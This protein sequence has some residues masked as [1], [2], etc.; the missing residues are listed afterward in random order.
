[1]ENSL[2]PSAIA[3]GKPQ[4]TPLR[5]ILSVGWPVMLQTFV[6]VGSSLGQ[7]MLLSVC[8]DELTLA[9][10]SLA[11]V[12]CNLLGYFVTWGFCAGYDTIASQAWGAG[13]RRQIGVVGQR[14]VLMQVVCICAPMSIAW[15]YATYILET[16][17]Q[18]RAV[19]EQA[20]IY[21]RLSLPSL[22]TNTVLCVLSKALLAMGKSTPVSVVSIVRTV[23]LG[24]LLVLLVYYPLSL[25]LTGAALANTISSCAA[26]LMLGTYALCDA[27]CRSCWPGCTG[28]VWRRWCNYLTL[29]LP[30]CLMM[31]CEALSWDI[32]SFLA[33]L[34]HTATGARGYKPQ[35]IIAAQGLLQSI[36]SSTCV[37]PGKDGRR[38]HSHPQP[39]SRAQVR[40]A[41]R[42]GPWHCNP[43]RQRSRRRRCEECRDGCAPR[44]SSGPRKHTADRRSSRAAPRADCALLSATGRCQR[45][46]HANAAVRL[47][48]SRR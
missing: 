21:A 26:P 23:L 5:V 13:E 37:R 11:N 14:V 33:G 1:M 22:F 8:T 12:L 29:G 15:W 30:A 6:G 36:I 9:G 16:L 47:R 46:R 44:H 27:D 45:D 32:V 43:Y 18:P 20:S 3:D 17:G 31:L 35:S 28:E 4:A 41:Y 7:F 25:G 2:L 48:I 19:A 24:V 42:V 34:C 40:G 38:S 39:R 10:F